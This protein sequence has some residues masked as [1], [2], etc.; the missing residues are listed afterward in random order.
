MLECK[1][2]SLRFFSVATYARWL[3]CVTCVILT[4][5]ATHGCSPSAPATADADTSSENLKRIGAAYMQVA[6]KLRRP[7]RGARDLAE[8][9]KSGPNQ[10]NPAD[11]LHSPS[12][13]E[14]YVIVWGVDFRSLAIARGNVDVVLAYEK[15]GKN[16]KRHVLKPPAQIIVMTDEE[17]KKAEFPP[18]H[19][20]AL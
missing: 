15:L 14:D 13:N 7:P 8:A 18:G 1:T 19:K 17:F 20:P 10:P 9:I 6:T 2:L 4:L 11:I 5:A 12:D 3:F 16:G